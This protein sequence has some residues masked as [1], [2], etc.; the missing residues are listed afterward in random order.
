MTTSELE[1]IKQAILNE[2]E[3]YEFYLMASNEVKDENA[4]EAFL[5]LANEEKSHIEWLKNL[6]DKIK[7]SDKDDLQL[8]FIRDAK[9]PNIYDWDKIDKSNM[10]QIMT[11][12]GIAL[13][14]EKDS[15]KFYRESSNKLEDKE[16]KDLFD[17]LIKWEESHFN[18]FLEQ[19]NDLKNKWWKIKEI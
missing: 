1:I 15:V 12:F 4:K 6:F 2:I 18:Q 9:S 19:Y 3:G 5:S 17:E 8:L 13:S 11:I 16:T 14:K 10:S 7:N